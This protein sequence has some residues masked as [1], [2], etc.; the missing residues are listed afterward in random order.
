MK[1]REYRITR[2]KAGDADWH[3]SAPPAPVDCFPWGGLAG[4][5]YRPATVAKLAADGTA[6]LVRME[7]DEEEQ[8]AETK[9]F[10]MTHTDSCMEFFL[11]PD[12]AGSAAYLNWEFNPAG[13][14]YLS[15]GTSRHDRT[16]IPAGDYRKL[17]AVKTGTTPA[18]WTLEYR[19]PLSFLQQR[20]PSIDLK[21][22]RL[23]RGN[24]YKCGDLTR[25]PHY[26][27]WSPIN[28]PAPDFHCPDFFG[29][30]VVG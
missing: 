3:R 7:T 19:I 9:G 25:R 26:G 14:M 12:P 16:D 29:T 2:V 11:S 20:F 5:D 28:L 4:E 1:P 13:G 15:T 21:A 6:I 23:M 27:C 18:G 22:G 10:G 24:F 30:L 17:F 8:R